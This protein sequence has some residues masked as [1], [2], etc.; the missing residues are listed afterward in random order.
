MPVLFYFVSVCF[1]HVSGRLFET[2]QRRN[3][4]AEKRGGIAYGTQL[5]GR[6]FITTGCMLLLLFAAGLMWLSGSVREALQISFSMQSIL[7]AVLAACCAAAGLLFV[8][9]LAE[10]ERSAVLPAGFAVVFMCYV[11]GCFVPSA[12][13]PK[14]VNRLAA[15]LP[16][17]Y[18]KKA[19]TA[20][21]SG[22]RK[23]R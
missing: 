20:L 19:F 8:Y 14:V 2:Q 21:F 12:I 15:A 1:G 4:F 9:L 6:T 22:E 5:L 17:T 3:A 16:T 18:V 10:G 13:L 7:L 11:S 23:M